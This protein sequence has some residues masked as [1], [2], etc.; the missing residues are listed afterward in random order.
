MDVMTVSAQGWGRRL[1]RSG[2]ALC[3]AAVLLAVPASAVDRVLELVAPA[4][5]APHS[6]VEVALRASTNAGAKEQIGFLQVE[7]SVDGGKTWK[8]VCYDQSVGPVAT[9][10]IG[11][12]AGNAGTKV[13]VRARV[14]FRGGVAGD[15][16][17]AGAA[18]KWQDTWDKW[19][20]PPAR[21]VTIEIK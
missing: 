6:R 2:S 13:V 20:V 11:L 5:A 19:G 17:Y 21:V 1:A 9:R 18:I 8:G 3:F 14:A 16:D 12:D 4:T 7:T 15:V 10:Q